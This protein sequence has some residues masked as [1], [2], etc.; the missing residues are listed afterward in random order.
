MLWNG[1]PQKLLTC[2]Y[3]CLLST[4]HQ[5][6]PTTEREEAAERRRKLEAI[7]GGGSQFI[8]PTRDWRG[9]SYV[10]LVLLLLLLLCVADSSLLLFFYRD[11]YRALLRRGG[12]DENEEAFNRFVRKDN[13]EEAKDDEDND[14]DDS[15]ASSEDSHGY[16]PGLLDDPEMVLGR[17][18]NVMIGSSVTGPIVS[19]TI[20]F[21]D[22]VLLKEELNKQFRERFDGWEPPKS[23]RKYIGARVVQ[24]NYVLRDPT[25][26]NCDNDNHSYEQQQQQQQQQHRRRK[27]QGS[28]ASM[29][30]TILEDAAAD[31][32]T[33][34]IP[35]SLTLSKIRSLKRQALQAAVQANLNIGSLA[36]SCVYFE[37]LCLDC[38]VDKSNRRLTFAACILLAAKL[39]E[40]NAGLVMQDHETKKNNS[41][42]EEN[43]ERITTRIQSMIIKPNKRS[44]KMFASLLYFF[45][46]SWHLSLK[47]LFAAEWGVFAALGF[48]LHASPSHVAFHFLRLMKTLEWKPL[49]YLGPEMHAQWQKALKDD[50]ERRL[51]RQRRKESLRKQKEERILNLHMEIESELM[52][53]QTEQRMTT[54]D[55]TEIF[56]ESPSTERRQDD[57]YSKPKKA[58]DRR[59]SLFNRLVLRKSMS[60][61]GLQDGGREHVAL[62]RTEHDSSTIK[63]RTKGPDLAPRLV[64]SPSMPLLSNSHDDDDNDAVVIDIPMKAESASGSI[65]RLLEDTSGDFMV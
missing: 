26:E 60:H 21:V 29:E 12:D 44:G 59:M 58:S 52:R 24:G 28:V 22:P 61:D 62:S 56:P 10:W 55:D 4:H 49:E 20:Q 6:P 46:E 1:T 31:M 64:S 36:L 18:R 47:H 8:M 11:R 33:M 13:D 37:R 42:V 65:G 38:R 5:Q 27:R 50:E 30:D 16:E 9:I 25:D 7:G 19:S 51:K 35:P 3:C 45:T 54:E 39:N 43:D 40:P 41:S 53:R 23:A 15:L 34:R 57:D 63:R 14:D 32:T 2:L 17:H 48:S